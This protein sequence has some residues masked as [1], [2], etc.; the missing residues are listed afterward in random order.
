MTHTKKT[1]SNFMRYFIITAVLGWMGLTLHAQ[2]I[3][4]IYTL[5]G[6]S[7]G[8]K[9]VKGAMVTLTISGSPSG[10]L[11]MS[12]IKPGETVT[13]SG[14]FKIRNGKI[15]L[16]FNEMEWEATNAPYS[17][18]GNILTLPFKALGGEGPGTST[19]KR[20]GG[21]DDSSGTTTPGK[22]KTGQDDDQGNNNDNKGN[23]KKD[24]DK[25]NQKGDDNK[26]DNNDDGEGTNPGDKN[27]KKPDPKPKPQDDPSKKPNPKQPGVKELKGN[28]TG[29]AAGE[30]VRFRAN[31]GILILTVKHNAEFFFHIDENGNIDGEG[32]IEYDLERNTTGLDN[33]A[34]GVRGL[35]GL[36][37]GA[38]GLP[39][40]GGKAALA[41]K[42]GDAT[43][44]APG[45][46]SLQYEAPHLKNGKEVRHFKFS[47]KAE[48]STGY[49]DGEQ[50]N[51]WKLTLQ[52]EGDFTTPD[53]SAD[54]QLIAAWE[55][56][57]VKEE[58]PFPCWSP[59]LKTPATLRKGPGGIWIA[60][61]QEKGK[62][63]NGVKVW[64][65][66]GYVW[67]ARQ[68]K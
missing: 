68:N 64:Q 9:V 56:N 4:G 10:S 8:T 43:T 63:R 31:N 38:P 62:N 47:G 6:D 55:V 61:F 48:M 50:K 33:L 2:S 59:F 24:S 20:L 25:G 57:L 53:G 5:I 29:R 60:E 36:M 37:P 18:N 45:V 21:G 3:D 7:D 35:M 22:K 13:D 12:A 67:M 32:T 27:G 49:W 16:S 65:E 26:G 11:A 54:N 39:G 19:W 41:G 42:M 30:E 44:G 14:T 46:T 40:S 17:L 66:Y 15:T 52:Q 28:W 23:K 1:A 51:N 58:K 34:A